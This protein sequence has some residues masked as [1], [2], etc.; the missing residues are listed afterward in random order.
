MSKSS[1][2]RT[3]KTEE[4]LSLGNIKTINFLIT[5]VNPI[6]VNGILD[7]IKKMPED[8]IDFLVSHKCL[9]F[10]YKIT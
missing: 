3:V 10:T 8:P 1:K 6:L 5:C 7:I 4:N 9:L 2:E